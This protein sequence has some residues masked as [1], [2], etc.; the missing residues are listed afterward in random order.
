MIAIYFRH[1]LIL[2]LTV[3][4]IHIPALHAQSP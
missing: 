2:F 3:P 4:A 1:L